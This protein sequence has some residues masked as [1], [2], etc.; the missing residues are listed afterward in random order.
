MFDFRQTQYRR[1][2]NG[3]SEGYHTYNFGW[4]VRPDKPF[5]DPHRGV[6]INM[7]ECT[8][9]GTL[10]EAVRLD[11]NFT[12]LNVDTPIIAT[13][14]N[15]ETAS[16]LT[17]NSDT[18]IDF[19]SASIGGR[20]PD[21][22]VISSD[23]CSNRTISSGASCKIA[24]RYAS[25]NS[26]I[27]NHALLKI[28]NSSEFAPELTVS[29]YQ[30]RNPSS[31]LPDACV[32]HI[33][34]GSVQSSWDY[35]CVSATWIPI[36]NA[37]FF[38]FEL[39]RESEVNISVHSDAIPKIFLY[40]SDDVAGNILGE[41]ERN[42]TNLTLEPGNY[43]IEVTTVISG[44]T[45]EFTLILDVDGATPDQP[46]MTDTCVQPLTNN[47][48]VNGIWI[49]DCA[50]TNKSGSYA[51]YYTFSL[52]EQ[53]D[54]TVTLASTDADTYLYLL[55]GAGRDGAALHENDDHATLINTEACA[56]ASRLDTRTPALPRRSPPATTPLR[57]RPTTPTPKANSSWP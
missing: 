44:T 28:P 19:G 57:Q 42:V 38:T 20:N 32:Q 5:R 39:D 25:A 29:L 13:F 23:E 45:G 52:S 8:E 40:R 55:S 1:G 33:S 16:T 7:I 6:L 35:D 34:A 24:V 9:A 18:P 48:A 43:T 50:S 31:S 3:W 14:N 15:G 41:G 36:Y 51:R 30:A 17:N 54:V 56:D 47:G 21:G 27:G 26:Y 2:L 11:V 53:S 12:Q 46:P 49:D 4:T 10:R 22:F 37:R